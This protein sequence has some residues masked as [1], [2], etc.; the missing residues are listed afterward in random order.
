M[1]ARSFEQQQA[2]LVMLQF[3]KGDYLGTLK[4]RKPDITMRWSMVSLRLVLPC[5]LG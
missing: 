2:V 1:Y 5:D 3:V 4:K